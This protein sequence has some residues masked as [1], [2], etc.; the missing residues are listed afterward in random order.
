MADVSYAAKATSYFEN[1]RPEMAAFVPA[2]ARTLL[3]V[4]CGSA[5][6]AGHLKTQRELQVTGIELHP[7]A[8]ETARGRIDR[9]LCATVE[10]ALPQ[11]QGQQFDCIVLND[12][13]EHLV[14]PWGLLA[15]LRPLLAPGGA[16]VASI[17]N[18]RY[19]PVLKDYLLRGQ[20][21]YQAEG[22]L[23]RTH[24]R[25]FTHHGMRALFEGAGFEVLKLEGINPV[26]VS[27]KFRLL[28]RLL[29]GALDDA[30]YLQ[31]ACVA[32]AACGP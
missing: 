8:A 18:V 4:G 5:G 24:L 9:V 10:D 12:V 19:L 14:D 28:N 17:P 2:G 25:F 20:W 30:R 13:L 15:Q 32:R 21:R 7:Q 1:R 16:V 31:F 11:L 6:F 27:W 29:R 23:D 3:D 22:V 26:Q